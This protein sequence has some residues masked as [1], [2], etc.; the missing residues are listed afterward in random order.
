MLTDIYVNGSIV[1]VVGAQCAIFRPSPK[2]SPKLGVLTS[3]FK[4]IRGQSD[5]FKPPKKSPQVAWWGSKLTKLFT[6]L[7]DVVSTIH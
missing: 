1:N 2:F 3:H 5:N 7:F 6:I 4:K